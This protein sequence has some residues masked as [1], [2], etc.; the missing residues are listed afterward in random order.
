MELYPNL[1]FI[2]WHYI[3]V[4]YCLEDVWF[5]RSTVRIHD[6]ISPTGT[7]HH[8]IILGRK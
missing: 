3:M 7:Q 5:P 1:A 2:F 8:L 4:N 6:V